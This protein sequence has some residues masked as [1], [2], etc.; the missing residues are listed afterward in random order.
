MR[1]LV[2]E[3][4]DLH[5]HFSEMG[6]MVNE[7]INKAVEAFI[8][9]DKALAK[10]VITADEQINQREIDLEKH[11]LEL[12]A[13]QQPVTSNLRDIITIMKASNNLERIGDHAVS[14]A[15]ITIHVKGLQRVPAIESDIATTAQVVKQMMTDSLD[16]YLQQNESLARQIA[17]TDEIVNQ[18]V[19]VIYKK[20]INVMQNDQQAVI[21]TMDYSL[22]ANYLERIG[23]YITNICEWIVYLRTGKLLELHSN[24][25]DEYLV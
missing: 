23:D 4:N 18:H 7:A 1:K 2:D 16:A 24:S 12:I 25:H 6:M 13:L 10:L 17:K 21:G 14:I 20:C 22:V 5:I 19:H 9:H 3:L 15:R 8:N 11:S